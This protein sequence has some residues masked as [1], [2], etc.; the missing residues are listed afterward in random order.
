M[1]ALR[2]G[3]LA[4]E[5]H[6]T[7]QVRLELLAQ[8]L[9]KTYDG[10]DGLPSALE[11]AIYM[12]SIRETI[13]VPVDVTVSEHE[14]L[15]VCN[16][17][18]V[19]AFAA[20]WRDQKVAQLRALLEIQ[21][22][23]LPPDT[24]VRSLAVGRFKCRWCPA[25]LLSSEA[26]SHCCFRGPPPWF[27]N[28]PEWR[29]LRP[30]TAAALRAFIGVPYTMIESIVPIYIAETVHVLELSGYDP[31]SVTLDTMNASPIRLGCKSCRP[32]MGAMTW[33][34]AVSTRLG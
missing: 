31:Q 16:A 34:A 17:A 14:L 22:G 29:T 30:Y 24:D 26:L 21:T 1:G 20:A 33:A 9:Q 11:V 28:E 7:L 5:R 12:P 19:S 15:A 3:R 10:G 27:R 23:A 2:E 25:Q 13:D 32:D 18:A 8:I 6:A 4:R